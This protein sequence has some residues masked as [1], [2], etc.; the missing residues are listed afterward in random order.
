MKAKYELGNPDDLEVTV[1]ITATVG[2][3]RGLIK[4]TDKESYKWPLS[5]LID[6]LRNVVTKA[7]KAILSNDT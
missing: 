3:L 6:T 4:L 7:D 1:T 5:T 2:D